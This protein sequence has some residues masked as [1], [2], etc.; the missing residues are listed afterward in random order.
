MCFPRSASQCSRLC[1]RLEGYLSSAWFFGFGTGRRD[2]DLFSGARADEATT[3]GRR[4]SGAAVTGGPSSSRGGDSWG[5]PRRSD[6]VTGG[7]GGERPR[8]TLAKRTKPAPVIKVPLVDHCLS[9]FLVAALWNL[10]TT[11][12]SK[13]GA[14]PHLWH[15][16][17]EPRASSWPQPPFSFAPTSRCVSRSKCER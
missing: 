13:R 3:W 8:L 15:A 4:D 5:A 16:L 2:S 6:S 14:W 1:C 11:Y 10:P 12:C 7:G 17:D 9:S